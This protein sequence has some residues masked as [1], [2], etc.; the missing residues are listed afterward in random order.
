MGDF[1]PWCKRR[2]VVG[3]VALSWRGGPRCRHLAVAAS[4][5]S[6]LVAA[7]PALG[8]EPDRRTIVTAADYARAEQLLPGNRY[9]PNPLKLGCSNYPPKSA[10]SDAV[11]HTLDGAGLFAA[12]AAARPPANPPAAARRL[13]SPADRPTARSGPA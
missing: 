2:V 1:A 12:A 6:A 11:F 3:N 9:T 7:I 10:L 4:G 8:Q 13:P 5:V